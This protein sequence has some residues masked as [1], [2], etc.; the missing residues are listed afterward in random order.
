MATTAVTI[1]AFASTLELAPT[2]D[3]YA[4]VLELP[5]YAPASI[6]LAFDPDTIFVRRRTL[7]VWRADGFDTPRFR[8]VDRVTGSVARTKYLPVGGW[9]GASYATGVPVL[10]DLRSAPAW[11]RRIPITYRGTAGERTGRF[12]A[13]ARRLLHRMSEGFQRLRASVRR[14]FPRWSLARGGAHA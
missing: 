4:P 9:I 7:A 3:R 2:D 5:G 1:S 8:A 12:T 13:G 14:R 11:P 6:E 10:T